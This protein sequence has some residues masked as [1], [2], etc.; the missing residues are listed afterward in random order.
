MS[1]FVDNDCIWLSDRSWGERGEQ[2]RLERGTYQ[3]R[4][5]YT[6]R[7]FFR[8]QDGAW[9]WSQPKPSSSGKVWASLSLKQR[10]LADLGRVL[11]AEAEQE[12]PAL[13]LSQPASEREPQQRERRTWKAP[14]PA[15][16]GDLAE[17]DDGSIPF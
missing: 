14:V 7:L 13:D 8:T 5:T 17:A 9:R 16:S 10:E 1:D 11:L 2:L 4:L 6:L 15:R 12:Q 3:G